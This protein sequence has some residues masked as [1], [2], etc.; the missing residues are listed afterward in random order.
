MFG[1]YAHTFMTATRTGGT[2]ARDLPKLRT[3][4]R[5]AG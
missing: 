5:A 4:R 2:P 1:I 3:P